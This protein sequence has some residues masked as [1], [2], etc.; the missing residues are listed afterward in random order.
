[1]KNFAMTGLAGYVAPRHLTAI[2]DTGNRL[3]AALDPNDSVGVL[4]EFFPQAAFFTDFER[5]DRNLERLRRGPAE[6]R[7]DYLSICAPNYVH[8]AHVR[9]ALRIGAAAICE[10]PLVINPWNLD[11]L[12]K[13]ESESEGRVFAIRQLRYLPGIKKLKQQI[14]GEESGFVHDVVLSNITGRGRWYDYSWKG[15]KERSGGL[16]VNIGIHF[17]D[18]LLWIF[19]PVKVCEVHLSEERR[20]AGYLELKRARVRW[21]LSIDPEDAPRPW[22][23]GGMKERSLRVDG[24]EIDLA[25]EVERLH[26]RAYQEILAGGGLGIREAR[27]AIELVHRIRSTPAGGRREHVHPRLS[28]NR[29]ADR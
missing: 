5:F 4:D 3:S 19:G 26:T 29:E 14:E 23:P 24:M 7:I 12:E 16:V 27:P 22:S 13:M 18:L 20:A 17:F 15:L 21:F 6:N 25:G 8:D 2:R 28:R 10:K 11:A 1:M 9:L